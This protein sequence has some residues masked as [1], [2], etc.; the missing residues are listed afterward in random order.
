MNDTSLG[1]FIPGGKSF[2]QESL[3]RF[4]VFGCHSRFHAASEGPDFAPNLK[5]VFSMRH[6]LSVSFERR[7]VSSRF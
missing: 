7:S 1:R 4:S 3:C 5:I 6:R 2:F